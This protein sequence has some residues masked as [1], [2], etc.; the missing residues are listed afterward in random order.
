MKSKLLNNTMKNYAGF[1]IFIGGF[2][3]LLKSNFYDS[4]ETRRLES[5]LYLCVFCD[6][7]SSTYFNMYDFETIKNFVHISILLNKKIAEI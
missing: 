1:S 7:Q 5:R 2:S 3:K 6:I 4:S